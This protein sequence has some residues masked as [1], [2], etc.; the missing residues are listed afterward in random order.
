MF[1]GVA[2][3]RERARLVCW[4]RKPQWPS[5]SRA[6][7]GRG[8][9][10]GSGGQHYAVT[11]RPRVKPRHRPVSACLCWNCPH[12]F[13]GSSPTH[14]PQLQPLTPRLPLP[15]L[16]CRYLPV[17]G[18]LYTSPCSGFVIHISLFRVC[19]THLPV[20]GLLFRTPCSGLVIHI[21]L[22]RVCYTHILSRVCYRH[23]LVAG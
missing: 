16:C 18:L 7:G 6:A 13:V 10:G 4:L 9:A 8:R 5:G 21:S 15:L 23:L 1:D 20:P 12:P 2:V 11:C 22:F 14:L 17:P 3:K 19:Y